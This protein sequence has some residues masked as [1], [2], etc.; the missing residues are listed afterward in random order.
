MRTILPVVIGATL[1]LC[2]VKAGAQAVPGDRQ[3][4]L[5]IESKTLADALDQWAQQSGFQILLKNWDVAKELAAPRLKGTFSAQAALEQLLS[6]TPLV[7]E[8]TSERTVTVKARFTEASQATGFLDRAKGPRLQVA[9]VDQ[10]ERGVARTRTLDADIS[11]A[12]REKTMP[13]ARA[14]RE[15][16]VEELEEVVVTGTHIR[17][18]NLSDSTVITIDRIDIARSGFG[19]MSQVVAS[20]PQ[21]FGG[22]ASPN[23]N[24]NVNRGGSELN[25]QLGTGIN[26]R[27]LGTGATLT[28]LNGHRLA[29][30]GEGSFIDIS[31]IPISVI[32]R[33]EVLT[34][35][36]SAIYGSDA[37]AG[38]VNIITRA[39]FEGSETSA[40]FGSVSEG[41]RDEYS[42]SQ[43]YGNSWETGGFTLNLEHSRET[44]LETS[45]RGFARDV[46][47]PS[48]LLPS[49]KTNSIFA[50]ARQAMTAQASISTDI[51]Y[52]ER[53]YDQDLTFPGS[54]AHQFGEASAL[55]AAIALESD[56]GRSWRSGLSGTYSRNTT[57]FNQFQPAIPELGT[58]NSR[59]HYE[60]SSVEA[61]ADGPLFEMPAGS[62]KGAIGTSYRK[63]R[64]NVG[65][66][67]QNTPLLYRADRSITSA[68][69]EFAVPIIGEAFDAWGTRSLE[70]TVAGR[71]DRY[72]DFGSTANPKFGLVWAPTR[73]IALAGTYSESFR[74]PPFRQVITPQFGYLIDVPDP[75]SVRPDGLTTSIL[76]N[77]GNHDLSPE[78]S[79]S[80][81]IGL[82][83]APESRHG[84]RGRATYFDISYKNRIVD[85]LAD[86]FFSFLGNE[87]ALSEFVLRNPDVTFVRTLIGRLAA[88]IDD[89]NQGIPGR[90]DADA[91][92]SDYQVGAFFDGRYNNVATSR[93]SGFD[94]QVS[95][96]IRFEGS[97]LD[98]QLSGSY[99]T[100][101]SIRASAAAPSQELLDTVFQPIDL[102]LR[103]GGGW[104]AGNFFA[105]AFVNYADDYK[106]PGSFYTSGGNV[107]SWMTVD[108]QVGYQWNRRFSSDRNVRMALSAL[109]VL[110]EDPPQLSATPF[111]LGYDAENASPLG[112]FI[113]VNLTIQWQ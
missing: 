102:R 7:Y 32:E 42:V 88:G 11:G 40:R 91:I 71:V 57:R 30:A 24:G 16:D 83:L 29:P 44:P 70:L 39:D 13:G 56:I 97:Q 74:A 79:I 59:S 112:R 9:A 66:L 54:S 37:I 46:P 26:L 95:Q 103:A 90:T 21:N 110:D 19:N 89:F 92:F 68:Y 62:V 14:D 77:G 6:G 80:K 109:N 10:A 12:A 73:G 2:A 17:G 64:S 78:T 101:Y 51:L 50:S 82:L 93:T 5:V 47:S 100:D 60:T 49:Q 86:N 75:A 53:K 55:A 96:R 48:D 31:L 4:A 61:R 23:V 98:L 84:L 52:T 111:Q 27:G 35:G 107:A 87:G 106:D 25:Q 69:L 99:L 104:T 67:S 81:T 113:A 94:V 45:D 3:V 41:D 65:S 58:L 33:V 108:A 43:I 22:G 85:L 28:L 34:D 72:S 105:S 38:V 63:E 8:F 15:E 76:V 36:A 18:R 20:L 1:A